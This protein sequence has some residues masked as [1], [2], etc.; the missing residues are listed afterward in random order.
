METSISGRKNARSGCCPSIF[1]PT[2]SKKTNSRRARRLANRKRWSR[3][4]E[5]PQAKKFCAKKL[6]PSI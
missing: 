2:T 4:A 1:D 3:E 6:N 5:Q